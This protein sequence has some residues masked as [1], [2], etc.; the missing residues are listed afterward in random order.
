SQAKN[1]ISSDAL[2]RVVTAG[3]SR[4]KRAGTSHGASH[5]RAARRSRTGES[6]TDGSNEQ[7]LH[8]LHG[9]EPGVVD[10]AEHGRA[11]SDVDQAP[12]E[13]ERADGNGDV[14]ALVD[15]QHAEEER[16]KD[17][18]D[19]DAA[20]PLLEAVQHERALHLFAKAARDD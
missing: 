15:V 9:I 14:G 11:A 5:D 7:A 4:T 1:W 20:E 2:T 17:E 16:E 8:D 10:H 18:A 13:A 19:A 6:A 3:S 12:D